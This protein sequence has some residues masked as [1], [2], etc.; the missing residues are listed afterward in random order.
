MRARTPKL[1]AV[2]VGTAARV[3]PVHAAVA[4]LQLPLVAAASS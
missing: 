1:A 3:S 4:P 2:T